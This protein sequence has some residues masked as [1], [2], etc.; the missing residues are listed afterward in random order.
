VPVGFM[1]F[2]G[3][4]LHI[5]DIRALAADVPDTKVIIDHFGFCKASDPDSEEWRALLSLAALPQV[6]VKVRAWPC[7]CVA[8]CAPRSMR[9]CVPGAV[10]MHAGRAQL[11]GGAGAAGQRL[12]PH[13]RAGLPIP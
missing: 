2:K 8:P 12:L 1:T 13:Q 3:L 4:L 5:S 9:V 10:T 7:A 11:T 6:Y